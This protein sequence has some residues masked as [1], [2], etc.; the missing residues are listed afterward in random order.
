MIT[1]IAFVVVGI[2]AALFATQNTLHGSITIASYTFT[3]I[4]M[5]LIVLTSLLI[6]LVLSFLISLFNSI[7]SSLTIHGKNV[8]IKET[9]Q[10]VNDLTKRIHQLELENEHLKTKEEGALIDRKSL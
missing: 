8:K 10:T 4:P 6:G 2:L 9:K 3:D 5:Y 7:S 1:L